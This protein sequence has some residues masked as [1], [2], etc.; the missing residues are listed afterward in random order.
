MSQMSPKRISLNPLPEDH[1]EWGKLWAWG[2]RQSLPGL[3]SNTFQAR[4]EANREEI[5]GIVQRAADRRGISFEEMKQQI[6][7]NPRLDWDS[8]VID[9]NED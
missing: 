2:K 1:D 8:D 5:R 3:I 9:K 6:L 4:V 7:K